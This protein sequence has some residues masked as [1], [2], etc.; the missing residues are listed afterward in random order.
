MLSA[1]IFAC[2]CITK[3][4]LQKGIQSDKVQKIFEQLHIVQGEAYL[5]LEK[6]TSTSTYNINL[7][8]LNYRES[9]P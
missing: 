9:K 6:S 4:N 5:H 2:A 1:F 7:K 8:S 3:I